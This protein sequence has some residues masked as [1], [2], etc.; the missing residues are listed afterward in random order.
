LFKCFGFV[1]FC[2]RKGNAFLKFTFT[3]LLMRRFFLFCGCERPGVF[4]LASP[5]HHFCCEKMSPIPNTV[6]R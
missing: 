6:I 2:A 1:C 5:S 4:L 3:V